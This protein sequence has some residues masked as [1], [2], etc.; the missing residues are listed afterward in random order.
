MLSTNKWRSAAGGFAVAAIIAGCG[1]TNGPSPTSSSGADYSG[2]TISL[3]AVIS[4]NGPGSVYGVQQR[5]G[6]QL[7]VDT[8]NKNGGVNGGKIAVDIQDDGSTQQQGAQ[9]FQ[10]EIQAGKVLGVI[11]PTLSNTAI[12]AHPVANAAK[13][14]VIAPS[15][16]GNGIV[17]NCPYPCDFI[18]R[19]SLGEATA[20]P[21]NVKTAVKNLHPKKAVLFYATDDKFSSDGAKI[22]QQAFTDNGITVPDGGVLQFSKTESSFKEYVTT[23]LSKNADIWAISSLGG[24]PAKVMIEARTQGYKGPFLGGNGFNTYQVSQ[25]AGESGKGAQS[26]SAYF[27]GTDSATNKAFVDAYKARFKDAQGTP[28]LPDQIAAQAYTAV[29]VFAQAAKDAH[30]RFTDLAADRVKLRDALAKVS[31][32]S[33]LGQFSFNAQHD[34]HQK[35]FVTGMD[36]KG[37]FILVDTYEAK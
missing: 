15:N 13:T 21:D 27:V 23:A 2:K 20:I 29:E 25:Q 11:G 3:G 12:A 37:G 19:D 17:G 26:G 34:V 8:I 28:Q 31:V 33:P 10:T 14:P 24:I 7:A 30:L 36:G 22:F 4:L 35:V 18:F 9:V 16:T 6:I 32:D 1:G 5:N